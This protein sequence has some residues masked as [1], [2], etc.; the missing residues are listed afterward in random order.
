MTNLRATL[1]FTL[2]HRERTQKNRRKGKETSGATVRLS[3]IDIS[4]YGNTRAGERQGK[5]G[6]TVARMRAELPYAAI[7][8]AL[9]ASG[10]NPSQ[11]DKS[12]IYG[13]VRNRQSKLHVF[14]MQ[15][16]RIRRN[17]DEDGS[18]TEAN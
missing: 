3:I 1:P 14:A 4:C 17:S 13:S 15:S 8:L 18:E 6:V 16:P 7:A 5:A 2:A 10:P 11:R 12:V 9:V